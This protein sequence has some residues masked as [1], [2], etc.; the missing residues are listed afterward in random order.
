METFVDFLF[1]A[2]TISKRW[3]VWPTLLVVLGCWCYLFRCCQRQTYR[4]R[5][6]GECVNPSS[7]SDSSNDQHFSLRYKLC[8]IQFAFTRQLALYISANS[9]HYCNY[10][11]TIFLHLKLLCCYLNSRYATKSARCNRILLAKSYFT[12]PLTLQLS[13]C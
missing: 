5:T 9:T 3:R 2:K 1:I 6:S 4:E 13:S 10:L 7:I 12:Y 11:T 8:Q